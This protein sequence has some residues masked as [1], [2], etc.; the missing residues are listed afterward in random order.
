[1]PQKADRPA[2]SFGCWGKGERVG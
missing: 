2:V 1:M